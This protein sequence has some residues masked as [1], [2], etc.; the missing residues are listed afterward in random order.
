MKK[1]FLCLFLVSLFVISFDINSVDA[2]K[3]TNSQEDY[4]TGIEG[5]G[6][7]VDTNS[8]NA[9]GS[10]QYITSSQV[11]EFQNNGY[12]VVQ[13]NSGNYIA[14]KSI[15]QSGSYSDFNLSGNIYTTENGDNAFC[16][17]PGQ[18]FRGGEFTQTNF[19]ASKYS[20][21]N[22]DAYSK[23]SWIL[24]QTGYSYADRLTA[25][26]AVLAGEGNFNGG[27][28]FGIGDGFS[29]KYDGVYSEIYE[30]STGSFANLS[31]NNRSINSNIFIMDVFGSEVVSFKESSSLDGVMGLIQKSSQSNSMNIAPGLSFDNL[32]ITNSSIN[33]TGN[34]ITLPL[35][36]SDPRFA[37]YADQIKV[38]LGR[39][40]DGKW[41]SLGEMDLSECQKNGCTLKTENLCS[42]TETLDEYKIKI[43]VPGVTEG[44]GVQMYVNSSNPEDTQIMMVVP[45]DKTDPNQGPGDEQEMVEI[46]S[47]VTINCLKDCSQ[48]DGVTCPNSEMKPHTDSGMSCTNK[49]NFGDGPYDTYATGTSEDPYMNCILNACDSSMKQEFRQEQYSPDAETCVIYCRSETEFYM[50]D[51]TKVYAGMQFEYDIRDKVP[52]QAQSNAKLSAVVFQKKQCTSEIFYDRAPSAVSPEY[53]GSKSWLERYDEAT[54][55]MVSAWNEYKYWETLYFWEGDNGGPDEV[56]AP[57]CTC[58]HSTGGCPG[59][60]GVGSTFAPIDYILY[61]PDMGKRESYY[62]TNFSSVKKGI[63]FNVP[64][65]KSA[66]S[67]VN[68]R[69]NS[70]SSCGSGGCCDWDT[71]TNKDG[72]VES[73]CSANSSTTNGTCLMGEAGKYDYVRN[74]WDAASKAYENTAKEVQRLIASL[75][76]CSLYPNN[77]APA[78]TDKSLH[79]PGI[80][81]KSTQGAINAFGAIDGDKIK[82]ELGLVVGY[83]DI[84]YGEE[85]E[86]GSDK[87][88]GKT[89]KYYCKNGSDE[90]QL[91][92]TSDCYE[93][94][95]IELE[96]KGGDNK[97]THEYVYCEKDRLNAKCTDKSIDLPV[98][99]Y[100]TYIMEEEVDFFRNVSYHTKA[101]TGQVFKG[102]GSGSNTSPLPSTIFPVSNDKKSGSTGL[103]G[104][105]WR[106]TNIGLFKPTKLNN[107]LYYC[108][109]EVYNTTTLYDC[110]YLDEDGNIDWEKCNNPCYVDDGDPVPEICMDKF[111]PTD[112]KGYGFIYRNVD[113]NNLFPTER[114]I[115]NN[116]ANSAEIINNI[117]ANAE[118]IWTDEYLEY[119]FTLTPQ[120]INNIRNYNNTKNGIGGYLD[121][122]LYSCD[123]DSNN[124]FKNCKSSFLDLYTLDDG[125]G[126]KINKYTRALG[127]NE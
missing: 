117:Q 111:K 71:H 14:Y 103:Y 25:A 112:S 15:E 35:D 125:L 55:A 45:G 47:N 64:E 114:V 12:S 19:D 56:V 18:L 97:E 63:N 27:D 30:M 40:V 90:K 72:S 54:K 126:V 46:E 9:A 11:S 60:C 73:T 68:G 119:S 86:F 92:D 124:A 84:N 23:V 49:D 116:W 118:R 77:L 108:S 70:C 65:K 88:E 57:G 81:S 96:K 17:T 31:Y 26:R 3:I 43:T 24:S 34:S 13:G 8:A 74:K 59:G 121:N 120:A 42:G 50:A 100:A 58:T 10:P 61:W 21:S 106:F 98:N 85:I 62:S 67:E 2:L 101:Y 82:N 127:G 51:K 41:E 94:T 83:E 4:E 32:G 53:S 89:E 48:S 76:S 52:F 33:V 29:S 87:K 16:L 6:Y 110:P 36:P 22:Q 20:Y 104:I 91:G 75:L 1:R 122:S 66:A 39:Y 115:G 99:D 38:E 107:F 7:G 69:Y 95:D 93:Y 44:G 105:D 80:N 113:L 37:P 78:V 109:Y 102:S 123:K 79:V 28:S 5:S